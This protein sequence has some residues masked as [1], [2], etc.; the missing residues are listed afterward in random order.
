MKM[1]RRFVK[2]DLPEN[3]AIK[4]NDSAQV[5]TWL[6]IELEFSSKELF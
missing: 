1:L 4:E 5:I 2:E 3:N 6:D